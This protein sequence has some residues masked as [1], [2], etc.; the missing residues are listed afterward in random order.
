[1]T[2][3]NIINYTKQE[4]RRV[5]FSYNVSYNTDIELIKRVLNDIF[6]EDERIL[7]D[8]KPIIGINSMSNNAMQIVARPWVKT[9]DYWDVYFDVMEKVKKKFDENNIELAIFVQQFKT[10]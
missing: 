7:Q 9:S 4:K 1:M 8:P 3:N 10:N 6:R 5:D 2:T